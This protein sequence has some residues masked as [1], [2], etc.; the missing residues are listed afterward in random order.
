MF[1]VFH[2]RSFSVVTKSLPFLYL[3]P[4]Q[5]HPTPPPTTALFK[6]EFLQGPRVILQLEVVPA[7]S[8]TVCAVFMNEMRHICLQGCSHHCFTHIV[9]AT[10]KVC[11]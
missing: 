3:G 5:V 2:L 11:L 9:L 8:Q 6:V 10:Q 7:H 1:A 4:L